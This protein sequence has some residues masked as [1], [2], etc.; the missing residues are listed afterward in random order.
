[1]FVVPKE[2]LLVRDPASLELLPA[3]GREVPRN[4]FWLRRLRDGDVTEKTAKPAR[5]R[6]ERKES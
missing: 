4:Q 3:E 6:R 5:V 1:M 2:D